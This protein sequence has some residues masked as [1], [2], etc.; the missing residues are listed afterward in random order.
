MYPLSSAKTGRRTRSS[1]EAPEIRN[2]PRYFQWFRLIS[3]P[4][5]ERVSRLNQQQV[6]LA[7]NQ[8]RCFR[9]NNGHIA[10]SDNGKIIDDPSAARILEVPA[11]SN[12]P[13]DSVG[14][15]LCAVW[16]FSCNTAADL[17]L[18]GVI[19]AGWWPSSSL[20]SSSNFPRL[21]EEEESGAFMKLLARIQSGYN[22][23]LQSCSFD[24]GGGNNSAAS[25]AESLLISM[26]SPPFRQRRSY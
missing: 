10:Y 5:T 24:G 11:V 13:V 6:D 22:Q 15:G 9:P 20:Y 17:F 23:V 12:D 8:P 1:A 7:L 16:M 4:E 2:C 26:T 18:Y 25:S 3:N 14:S 19:S 21:P